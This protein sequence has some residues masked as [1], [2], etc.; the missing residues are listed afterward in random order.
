[1]DK[2]L[3]LKQL[4]SLVSRSDGVSQTEA[5]RF[6]KELTQIIQ[7]GLQRDG[8]VRVAGLGIFKLKWVKARTMRNIQTGEDLFI[9]GHNRIYFKPEKEL[10]DFVNRRYADLVP[11]L[12]GKPKPPPLL[13]KANENLLEDPD[14]IPVG[15]ELRIPQLEGTEIQLTHNDSL[16]ISQGYEQAFLAYKFT[17]KETVQDFKKVADTFRPE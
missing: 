8:L 12:I 4:V 5:K 9:P 1:M 3:T 14:M 2:K 11:R 13:L 15:I 16:N 7:Q 6:L 10:R 17:G